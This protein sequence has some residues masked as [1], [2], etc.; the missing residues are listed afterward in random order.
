[1]IVNHT[2]NK[3]I[4][5]TEEN[6]E[7]LLDL[8][9]DSVSPENLL[10]NKTAHNSEGEGIVGEMPEGGTSDYDALK[11]RPQI[12]SNLLTGNKTGSQLGLQNRVLASTLN[13]G[14]QTIGNVEGALSALN[15]SKSDL[16]N[17]KV[18]VNELPVYQPVIGSI[19]SIGGIVPPSSS[20]DE[21]KYL[22]ADGTWA[23]PSGGGGGVS[24]YD[25]LTNRPKINGTTLSG[26]K[27]GAQLG[28][29]NIVLS[30][31][32]SI[33][34]QTVTEVEQALH[35]LNENSSAKDN[36]IGTK[37]EWEALTPEEQAKYNTMDFL[38]DSSSGGGG[39]TIV[40]EEGTELTQR[41]KLQFKGAVVSDDE[42]NDATVVD[43]EFL[44]NQLTDQTDILGAKNFCYPAENTK[45][46]NGIT[47]TVN[48]DNTLTI[49]TVAGG[50][51]G[52]GVFRYDG[53]PKNTMLKLNGCTVGGNASKYELNVVLNTTPFTKY[54]V[55][56]GEGSDAFNVGNNDCMVNIVIRSGQVITTPITFKPMLR[57][58]SD[59]DDTYVPYAKT[60]RELTEA[61]PFK[62]GIDANGNYGYIKAG[63]D[64]VTP[65]KSGSVAY[66]I[67]TSGRAPS[68]RVN[69]R[70]FISKTIA[71][72]LPSTKPAIVQ[73]KLTVTFYQADTS[74]YAC[75]L[76]SGGTTLGGGTSSGTYSFNGLLPAN[77]VLRISIQGIR[78]N[79]TILE[80][81]YCDYQLTE[82]YAIPYDSTT[83]EGVVWSV[84]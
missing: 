55:D 48:S 46:V 8:T 12:N 40:N 14:G 65:F 45:T 82:S 7:S 15:E 63:A 5:S 79:Y 28:L 81:V 36:F 11:N 19:Q 4:N 69:R 72:S 30:S 17:G 68:T 83:T 39:H 80:N 34:G 41:S 33:G 54:A 73:G 84:S 29:Q 1:M 42:T 78:E 47:F 77:Q 59:P 13:I 35:A 21:D 2:I 44:Q 25:D 23:K 62:L 53:V 9:A 60:N 51:T 22:R 3:V 75:I 61:L 57:L 10:L 76:T 27:T 58:A 64:S 18:P 6:T 66:S 16:V 70:S 24:D 38:G 26:D 37:Q 32:L 67:N 74:L 71:L 31:A 52:Q 43:V 49:S 56:Y 50:A 20:G